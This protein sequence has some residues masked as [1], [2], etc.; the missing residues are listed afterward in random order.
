M[1]AQSWTFDYDSSD[2][3]KSI[4]ERFIL[5]DAQ[6]KCLYFLLGIEIVLH[7]ELQSHEVFELVESNLTQNLPVISRFDSYYNPWDQLYGK[8]HNDHSCLITG[9]DRQSRTFT[10][11]DPYFGK[12]N[13][14][15]PFE[16]IE[17]AAG[18]HYGSVKLL[19]VV[20]SPASL[21]LLYAS[22]ER[23]LQENGMLQFVSDMERYWTDDLSFIWSKVSEGLTF[24]HTNFYRVIKTHIILNRHKFKQFVQHCIDEVG[25]H[26][27]LQAM[28][29]Q[30]DLIITHW[31]AAL[32]ALTKAAI[33]SKISP[34]MKDHFITKAKDIVQLE[35]GLA[36]MIVSMSLDSS[37]ATQEQKKAGELTE[38]WRHVQLDLSELLNNQGFSHE[39]SAASEA[40]ITGTGEYVYV[41]CGQLQSSTF[42][43]STIDRDRNDNISCM[44]QVIPIEPTR[45]KGVAILGCSE[46]G[47]SSAFLTVNHQD[48]TVKKYPFILSD[49]V[50]EPSYNESIEMKLSLVNKNKGLNMSDAYLF[51]VTVSFDGDGVI[52]SIQLPVCTNMHIIAM[53]MLV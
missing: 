17:Q 13:E 28:I 19:P 22:G 41:T 18:G 12:Q 5:S 21:E 3:G 48:G 42:H 2:G 44:G 39:L 10:I 20:D 16:V 35:Y 37:E 43:I 34:R 45:C 32:N 14:V 36:H 47:D 1:F 50:T 30:L 51:R 46:W 40:D 6:A 29:V 4:A 8:E 31:E 7:N 53:N 49:I 26:P 38:H 15:V 25:Q 27:V 11:C 52:D 33:Y 24:W 9:M 23:F